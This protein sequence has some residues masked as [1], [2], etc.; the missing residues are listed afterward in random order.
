MFH[1]EKHLYSMFYAVVVLESLQNSQANTCLITPHN[2]IMA[3]RKPISKHNGESRMCVHWYFA[4]HFSDV[5]YRFF[6]KSKVRFQ[7]NCAFPLIFFWSIV[8][9]AFD[10]SIK[11][12]S[13]Y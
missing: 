2:Q 6:S 3:Q 4:K 9:K 11:M 12:P 5:S 7:T 1:A 13:V 10:K 8:S